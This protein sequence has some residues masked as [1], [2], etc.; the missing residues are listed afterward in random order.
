MVSEEMII[1][2][3]HPQIFGIDMI[4]LDLRKKA[5]L[6]KES[7]QGQQIHPCGSIEFCP[8]DPEKC[9]FFRGGLR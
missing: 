1:R 7:H 4:K 5:Q 2:R 9:V 3:I 8:E 6:P